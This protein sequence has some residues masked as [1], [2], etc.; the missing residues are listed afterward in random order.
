MN[1][2]ITYNGWSNKETWTASLW[3][4]NDVQ[5]YHQLLAAKRAGRSEAAQAEWLASCMN[6]QLNQHLNDDEASIWMDLLITAFNRIDW[7]EVV[8]N[9]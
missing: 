1:E 3:L 6:E 9:N 7:N 8:R 2:A 5:L 4:N